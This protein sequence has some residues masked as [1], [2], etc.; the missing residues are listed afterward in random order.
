MEAVEKW[1]L[2]TKLHVNPKKTEM[3]RFTKRYKLGLEMRKVKLFHEELHLSDNA[4]YLGVYLDSKLSMNE[5]V[6]QLYNG[7]QEQWFLEPGG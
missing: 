2:E 3:V 7:P 4:K 6:R 1:C 5:H